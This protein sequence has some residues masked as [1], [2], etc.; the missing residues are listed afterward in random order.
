MVPYNLTG[1][2]TLSLSAPS[3]SGLFS[4]LSS[5]FSLSGSLESS[6]IAS[7]IAL[8]ASIRGGEDSKA[9][10]ILLLEDLLDIADD[11]SDVLSFEN[12]KSSLPEGKQF[13]PRDLLAIKRVV[14]KEIPLVVKA[15]R[16]SDILALIDLADRKQIVLVILGAAEGWIVANQLSVANVPV[17]LEP[18]NNLPGSFNSLG[19][20]LDNAALLHNSGVKVLINSHETHNA[21]LSRQGAGISVSYGLPWQEALKGLSINIADV[22]K[23]EKR[24][25]IKESYIADLVVWNADP[26]EITSFVEKVYLSGKSFSVENRSMR[27]RDR[28]LNN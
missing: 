15:N 17:I 5:A 18:I 2:I 8:I 22:F 14:N 6:L 13:S 24:G 19:A 16:A 27:L 7:D 11:Y 25:A 1:G 26:L 21:Y 10:N 4:G 3:S 28:Y 12:F 20:R 9:A 23:I